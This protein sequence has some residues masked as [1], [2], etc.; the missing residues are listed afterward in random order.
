MRRAGVT[1]PVGFEETVTRVREIRDKPGFAL[2][3][4]ALPALPRSTIHPLW[5]D[6][7]PGDFLE[8][9]LLHLDHETWTEHFGPE[10]TRD[11]DGALLTGDPIVE[12]WERE[13]LA[14]RTHDQNSDQD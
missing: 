5:P 3:Q 13:A 4:S 8:S 7:G 1:T 9:V 11:A 12:K 10:M 14:R 6:L 2:I